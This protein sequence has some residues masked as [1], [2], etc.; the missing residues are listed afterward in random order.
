MIVSASL[1]DQS[2][3]I[4]RSRTVKDKVHILGLYAFLV[5]FCLSIMLSATH[6]SVCLRF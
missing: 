1:A 4:V 3:E 2:E 6:A 5:Y